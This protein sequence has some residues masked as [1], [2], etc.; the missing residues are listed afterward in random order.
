M[1]QLEDQSYGAAATT[2]SPSRRVGTT[3]NALESSGINQLDFEPSLLKDPEQRDPVH[4][5]GLHRHRLDLTCRK[6]VRQPVQVPGK[7]PKLSYRSFVSILRHRHKVALCSNVD[8]RCVRTYLRKPRDSS[9]HNPLST[10]Y[11]PLYFVLVV[12]HGL[13]YNDRIGVPSREGCAV[14]QSLKR[15]PPDESGCHQCG[16]RKNPRT[17]LT[18]GQPAPMRVRS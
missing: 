9:L 14:R 12:P 3:R 5:C 7:G 15:D 11:R 2:D 4:P 6:P 18:N 10:V 8:P 16:C 1:P 17:M 13:L